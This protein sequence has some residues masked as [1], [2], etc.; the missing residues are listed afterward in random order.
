MK[1]GSGSG[2]LKKTILAFTWRNRKKPHKNKERKKEKDS[3]WI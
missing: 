1:A 2:L 3:F